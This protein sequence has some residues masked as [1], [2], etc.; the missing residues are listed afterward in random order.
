MI[1]SSIAF[2]NAFAISRTGNITVS[3][4]QDTL[5]KGWQHRARFQAGTNLN[6]WLFT[7]LRNTFRSQRRKLGREVGDD[8]RFA[9]RLASPACQHGRLDF[10]ALR[11]TIEGN[12]CQGLSRSI[13]EEVQFDRKGVKSDGLMLG[14]EELGIGSDNFVLALK[15]PDHLKA[16]YPDG[17]GIDVVE[18][19]RRKGSPMAD[20]EFLPILRQWNAEVSLVLKGLE[21]NDAELRAFWIQSRDWSMDELKEDFAWLNCF[22]DEYFFESQFGESSKE[23]VREFQAKG[24]FEESDGAVG[25]DLRK[26]MPFLK[27]KKEAGVA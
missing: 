26:M 12:V 13:H 11:R 2:P 3:L 19:L 21:S 7:I 10:A 18:I 24:V 23:L 4:V 20:R 15:I 5:L 25:A 1:S 6:A 8:G 27:K 9:E 14:E 16:A 22:F 17:I